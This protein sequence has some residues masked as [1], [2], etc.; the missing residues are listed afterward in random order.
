MRHARNQVA[1]VTEG[2]DVVG[3]VALEDLLEQ[4]IGQFDDETDPVI[5]AARRAGRTSRSGA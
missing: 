5:D 1:L 4:V 2:R 3:L